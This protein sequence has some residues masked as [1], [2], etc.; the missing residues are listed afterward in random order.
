MTNRDKWKETLTPEERTLCVYLL[1][2]TV[3]LIAVPFICA[4]FGVEPEKRIGAAAV[5]SA[6]FSVIFAEAVAPK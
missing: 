5:T 6:I 2:N 4:F 3:I 1:A